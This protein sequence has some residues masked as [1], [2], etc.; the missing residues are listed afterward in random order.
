VVVSKDPYLRGTNFGG[1]QKP[2]ENTVIANHFGGNKPDI[3]YDGSGS[4][5]QFRANYCDTSVPS[6]LCN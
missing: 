5:N 2:K 3:F 4:R 6:R 1:K